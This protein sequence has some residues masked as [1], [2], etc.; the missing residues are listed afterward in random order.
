[1]FAAALLLLSLPGSMSGQTPVVV[2][3]PGTAPI[4][5]KTYEEAGIP[6]PVYYSV[7]LLHPDQHMLHVHIEVPRDAKVLEL[8]LPVWNALYQV[9]IQYVNWVRARRITGRALEVRKL[10]KSRWEVLG[11]EDGAF[12]DYELFADAVGPSAHS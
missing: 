8:Q 11:A 1:M 10:E 3:P 4:R 5:T 12:V 7:S 9:R 6:A 2:S